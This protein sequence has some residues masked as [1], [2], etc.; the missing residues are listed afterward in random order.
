MRVTWGFLLAALSLA[1]SVR[2]NPP[3][4]RWALILEDPGVA[5]TVA[6]TSNSLRTAAATPVSARIAA[7]QRKLRAALAERNFVVT[8]AVQILMNAVFVEAAPGR[9][10]TLRS[11]PGVRNVVPLR[12]LRQKLNTAIDL[13]NVRGAWSAVGGMQNAGAGVKIGVIDTG[14]DQNHPAFLDGSL[15]PP[16]GFPK[17][18]GDDCKYTNKA[19]ILAKSAGTPSPVTF[20]LEKKMCEFVLAP[21]A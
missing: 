9:V 13:V 3:A 2:D 11:L 15:A 4:R 7:A 21:T 17:C 8:G 6:G 19:E 12:R 18:S 20:T 10:S 16:A 1:A 5:A 14:I